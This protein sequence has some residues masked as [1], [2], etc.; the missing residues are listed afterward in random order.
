VII[1]GFRHIRIFF[2]DGHGNFP[3]MTRTVIAQLHAANIPSSLPDLGVDRMNQP[4]DI[5]IGHFT[6]TDQTQIAA[7]M[8][9]GDLVVFA[10]EQGALKEVSRTPT[11]YWLLDIRSGSFRNSGLNDLYVMGTLF[12]GGMYPRPRLFY[13]TPVAAA[14]E[15]A[16]RFGGR[17]RAS[18][19]PASASALQ[20]QL[21]GECIE[22]ISDRWNFSRDGAFGLSQH[23]DTTI[24]A[25]F[26]GETIYY[27]L[28][29]PF[30]TY[31]VKG[32]LVQRDGVYAGTVNV[33]TSCG[34]KIMNITAKAE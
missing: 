4:R 31:P 13:G 12:W 26:D 33:M 3:R 8:G 21:R 14:N 1:P 22:E 32:E 25:V 19:P 27:R 9:E 34:W 17:G 6:R 29:A 10:Y 18:R 30:A 23:G 20:M 11:E 16:V 7:G 5:A 15:A 28:N 2:G 24:E